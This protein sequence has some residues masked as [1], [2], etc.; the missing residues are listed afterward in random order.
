[1]NNAIPVN[2]SSRGMRLKKFYSTYSR[3]LVPF[4]IAAMLI[5]A[6][7]IASPGFAGA[8]HVLQLLKTSALLGVLVL[9]QSV[10]IIAGGEGI[11]L[12]VGAVASIAAIMSGVLINGNNSAMILAVPVTLSFCLL[13]GLVNGMGVAVFNVPPLIMTLG[14]A[15]VINGMVLIYSKGFI[16]RGS[17]SQLLQTIGGGQTISNV[18]NM[19]FVWIVIILVSLFVFNRTKSGITLYGV[20][21]NEM[22][23]ELDGV[24]S[25]RVRALAYAAS[26][27]IAGLAG[28]FLLGYNG[29]PFMGIGDP[30]VLPSVAA[31]VIGGISLAGGSGSYLG[32][33]GGSILL[34]TLTALLVT[35]RMGEGGKQVVFGLVLIILLAL[36]GRRTNQ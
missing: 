21:A 28:I 13:L 31:A 7:E 14:M 35:L 20:G 29:L 30:Y 23:A 32:A 15:S 34:T 1:V 5:I 16:I 8:N 2:S 19:I 12:S 4:I 24:R 27:V 25:K 11:D 36:Y 10:V 3:V 22:T 18:P 6:G 26:G 33:V 17:A 9:A